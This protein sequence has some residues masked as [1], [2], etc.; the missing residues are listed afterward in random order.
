MSGHERDFC[1]VTLFSGPLT[2]I[3]SYIFIVQWG[4]LGA[5]IAM[6]IGL[7]LQNLLA[8]FMVKKRLW[9]WPIG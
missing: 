6:A 2:I 3:L 5:A 7:S 1:R 4:V 8:L 9:F